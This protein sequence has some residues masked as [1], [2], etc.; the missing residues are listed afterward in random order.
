MCEDTSKVKCFF[1]DQ[2]TPCHIFPQLQCQSYRMKTM[3]T[4]IYTNFNYQ[5]LLSSFFATDPILFFYWE[6]LV[7]PSKNEK[8]FWRKLLQAHFIFLQKIYFAKQFLQK[9]W[10]TF[11]KLQANAQCII[12]ILHIKMI[13]S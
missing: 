10:K 5:L 8:I 9:E 11:R 12:I 6:P 3:L 2:I 13:Q 1:V 4:G 7:Y